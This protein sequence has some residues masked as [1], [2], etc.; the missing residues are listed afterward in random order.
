MK[1]EGNEVSALL[2]PRRYPFY[3]DVV[4]DVGAYDG[5][6]YTLPAFQAGYRVYRQGCILLGVGRVTK[7]GLWLPGARLR[8]TS[9]SSGCM[10]PSC[11]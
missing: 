5:V 11:V 1:Q 8:V 3:Y 10:E 4:I 2:Q 6:D 9:L 7:C